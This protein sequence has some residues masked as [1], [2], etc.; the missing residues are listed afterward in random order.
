MIKP[1]LAVGINADNIF[2]INTMPYNVDCLITDYQSLSWWK[3]SVAADLKSC[4]TI[5]DWC[6]RCGGYV[7]ALSYLIYLD[8]K[9]MNFLEYSPKNIYN[10]WTIFQKIDLFELQMRLAMRSCSRAW[11]M[12]TG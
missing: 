4:A 1:E 12:R 5:H 11:V 6:I 3:F 7:C 9:Y 10:F 2:A 8:C